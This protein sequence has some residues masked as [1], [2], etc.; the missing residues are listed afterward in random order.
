ME[1]CPRLASLAGLHV[2]EDARACLPKGYASESLSAWLAF[3][4][5]ASLQAFRTLSVSHSSLSPFLLSF[6][7]LSFFDLHIFIVLSSEVFC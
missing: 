4:A 1:G 3:K 5:V 2:P 6:F 7:F